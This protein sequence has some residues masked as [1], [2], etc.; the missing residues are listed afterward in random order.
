MTE[1]SRGVLARR[2]YKKYYSN[3]RL[4]RW[5]EYLDDEI[6]DGKDKTWY[7][8][9]QLKVQQSFCNGIQIGIRKEWYPD[10]SPRKLWIFG[11]SGITLE[12]RGWYEN[13]KLQG[14]SYYDNNQCKLRYRTWHNNGQLEYSE[15]TTDKITTRISGTRQGTILISQRCHK[16]PTNPFIKKYYSSHWIVTYDIGV[17]KCSII[18]FQ[19]VLHLVALKHRVRKMLRRKLRVRCLDPNLI[20]DLGNIVMLYYF[21]GD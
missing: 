19:Q 4:Q 13:G 17:G 1:L 9:G 18:D 14:E 6:P 7:D 12:Y 21:K 20:S 11:D 5:K 10:G 8:N 3:G 15:F 16:D 2:E